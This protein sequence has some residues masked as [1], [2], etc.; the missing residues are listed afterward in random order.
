MST[1]QSYF[2]IDYGTRKIG[3]A[4]GQ[5]LTRTAMGI[6]VVANT[7]P[8]STLSLAPHARTSSGTPYVG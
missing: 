8:R 4:S 7:A 5:T 3:V 1:H 2:G 6:A